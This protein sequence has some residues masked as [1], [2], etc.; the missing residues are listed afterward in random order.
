MELRDHLR[1]VAKRWKTLVMMLLL[2]V[3]VAAAASATAPIRYES[4]V[5]LFVSVRSQGDA[6]D[7]LQG[8]SFSA[9]RV[10]SY[11]NIAS[12]PRVTGPVVSELD[13]D[14]SPQALAK[15]IRVDV[16]VDTVLINIS[17]TDALPG[18]AAAIAD[19]V[20]RQFTRVVESLERP[21]DA[22]T[23]PVKVT[24]TRPAEIA[25]GPVS[26]RPVLNVLLGALF[27][28][29]LGV[30]AAVLRGMLDT[31]INDAEGLEKVGG[32][33]VLGSIVLDAEAARINSDGLKHTAQ[34]EAYRQLRTNLQFVDVG[35]HPNP[36]VVTSPLAG[37]GKS[38]TAAKLSL[39]FAGAGSSVC[40]VDGD[41]RR[42]SVAERFQLTQEAGLTSVLIGKMTL[43]QA[44][45][46]GPS[47]LK[48]ITSGSRPPNPSELLA[49]QPMRDLLAELVKRFEI[50]I[51]DA[52]PLLPVTDAA[53]MSAHAGGALLVVKANGTTREQ[54]A[55]A[56]EVLS[57]VDARLLGSVLNMTRGRDSAS[58]RYSYIEPKPVSGRRGWR[59]AARAT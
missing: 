49:S 50:V 27:G 9:Q 15:R 36:I 51:I 37:E 21:A 43:D 32:A 56:A 16:P 53:V 29:L 54:T 25:G 35:G 18:D 52:P 1:T 46:T 41:F 28:C 4:T 34:G 6:S 24:V 8:G 23:S 10:K 2:G 3:V 42:P 14:A 19:A 59:G 48:V 44:I 55:K 31:R 5:Q 12:S 30:V 20:A 39:A 45:Q 57:A 11:A 7:L 40:L 26:P 58:Y 33:P 17:V 13:L 38:T 47:G 22:P